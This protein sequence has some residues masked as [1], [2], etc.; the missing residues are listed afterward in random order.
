MR[1]ISPS[2]AASLAALCVATFA[3]T[4]PLAA[5]GYQCDLV[6]TFSNHGPF[7]DVWGYVAPNGKE[8][9]LLGATTGLVVV[10]CS[11]PA[12]PIERGWFPWATS[13]WRDMRTYGHYV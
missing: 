5:Q 11:N 3:P 9:A 2:L 10:D 1:P 13:T 4:A 6:G 7:N 12:N 8:Y